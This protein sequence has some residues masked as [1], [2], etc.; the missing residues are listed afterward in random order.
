MRLKQHKIAEKLQLKMT[1]PPKKSKTA[2]II[3]WLCFFILLAILGGIGAGYYFRLNDQ[4]PRGDLFI[5]LSVLGFV[6][7]LLPIFL[8]HRW[9]G[10]RL[11]D[12][13]L[14]KEN[15]QRMKDKGI[16]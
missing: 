13:T 1:H 9:R 12:Y 7:I 8:V 16:D 4:I 2:K 5:G 10:K 6:F 15:M 11:Q 14:T 3:D